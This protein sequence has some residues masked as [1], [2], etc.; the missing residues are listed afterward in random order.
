MRPIWEVK[1]SLEETCFSFCLTGVVVRQWVCFS[2]H[3]LCVYVFRYQRYV[4]LKIVK[5]A[6]H[7]TETAVDE[8]ELLKRVSRIRITKKLCVC[9][10]ACWQVSHFIS[11]C[12]HG[13]LYFPIACYKQCGYVYRA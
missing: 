3:S 2:S 11:D 1:V 6:K 13:L 9:A 5:S 4:A 10:C 12:V 7:Y 8:I